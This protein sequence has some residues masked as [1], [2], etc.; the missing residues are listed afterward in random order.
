MSVTPL[1]ILSVIMSSEV[2]RTE[3]PPQASR[4]AH[5]PTCGSDVLPFKTPLTGVSKAMAFDN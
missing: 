1:E 5:A 3:L 4:F 2:I